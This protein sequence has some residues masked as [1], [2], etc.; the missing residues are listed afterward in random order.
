MK[1]DEKQ[2]K[3]SAYFSMFAYLS[4]LPNWVTYGTTQNI[5][6]AELGDVRYYIKYRETELGDVRHYRK[7]KECARWVY[8]EP[9][10]DYGVYSIMKL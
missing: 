1:H 6:K 3:V 7:C 2:K 9:T 10:H 4:T 5:E 8:Q